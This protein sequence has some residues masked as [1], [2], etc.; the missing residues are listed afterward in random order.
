MT[1]RFLELYDKQFIRQYLFSRKLDICL[2]S[3]SLSLYFLLS[4]SFVLS[5]FLIENLHMIEYLS[6]TS[7][8]NHHTLISRAKFSH[9]DNSLAPVSFSPFSIS[10]RYFSHVRAYIAL[11]F[12]PVPRVCLRGSR[13]ISVCT[14]SAA[15]SPGASLRSVD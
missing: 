6:S 3:L 8:W 12:S 5:L 7:T 13:S 9:I 1:R 10:R 14:L 4:R 2:F 15:L 11:S